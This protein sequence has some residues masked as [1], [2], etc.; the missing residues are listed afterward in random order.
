MERKWTHKRL[1]LKRGRNT[2]GTKNWRDVGE[3]VLKSS[4]L[5]RPSGLGGKRGERAREMKWTRALFPPKGKS[6]L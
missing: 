1:P 3:K 6:F 4:G 5:S 2:R